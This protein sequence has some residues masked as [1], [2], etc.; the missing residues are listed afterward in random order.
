M[1]AALKAFVVAAPIVVVVNAG[2]LLAENL[3]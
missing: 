1:Y 3:S 2:R